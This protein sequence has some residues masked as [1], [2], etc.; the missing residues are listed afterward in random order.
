MIDVQVTMP[1]A[2]AKEVEQRATRPMEKLI[3]EIPGVEYLYSTS[4]EGE[5]LVIVRFKVGASPET[6]LVAL[7]EKLRSNF[8][9]IPHGVAF[10]LIKPRSINDVPI[11]ALTLHGGGF[12]ALTLRRLAAQLDDT[13]KQVPEVAETTLI[14]GARRQVRVQLDPAQLAARNLSPAGLVPML[15]QANRQWRAGA[16]T[17]GNREVMIETGAFLTSAEDVGR[18]VVGVHGGLPVYLREVATV[19][20]TAEESSSYVLFGRGAGGNG[21]GTGEEPAVT[22]SVA[23]RPGANAIDVPRSTT[24]PRR[25]RATSS[26]AGAPG[27]TAPA[28]GR[29]QR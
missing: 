13:V 20:D 24:P 3:W 6:S 11:L 10:P 15:L 5:S 25:A 23:K 4:R 26:L 16:L 21:P 8:D 28:R 17:A 18:V 29:S 1:G 27:G 7:S 14:G 22:I 9:R 12:D 19:T 2:S